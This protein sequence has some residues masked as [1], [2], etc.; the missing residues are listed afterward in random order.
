VVLRK[1]VLTVLF[2]TV[3]LGAVAQPD[4]PIG[5]PDTRRLE[6]FGNGDI[7]HSATA[8]T[9]FMVV[10]A[11]DEAGK[12]WLQ[13]E[14]RGPFT[15]AV[16]MVGDTDR[17]QRSKVVSIRADDGEPRRLNLVVFENFVAIATRYEGK[18]DENASIFMNTLQGAKKTLTIAYGSESHNFDISHLS[19]PRARFMAL[20]QRQKS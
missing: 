18:P 5:L 15:V 14:R 12:F 3:A 1:L 20:C 9:Y 10:Q 4:I 6:T 2:G 17:R 13:C 16:A 7:R 19:E 8:D 11:T